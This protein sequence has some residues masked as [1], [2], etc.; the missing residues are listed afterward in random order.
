[1]SK[2]WHITLIYVVQISECREPRHTIAVTVCRVLKSTRIYHKSLVL[3]QTN[4]IM[5][6]L[7]LR[8]RLKI[9]PLTI[10]NRI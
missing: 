4:D 10:Y 2:A 9:N 1:M 6:K 5:N 8:I 3:C 7:N